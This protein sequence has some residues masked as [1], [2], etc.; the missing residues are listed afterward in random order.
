MKIAKQNPERVAN[1]AIRVPRRVKISSENGT[2]VR[3]I[4]AAGP[5]SQQIGPK[6]AD[7]VIGSGWFRICAGFGDFFAVQIDHET[8]GHADSR[9]CAVI[10]RDARHQR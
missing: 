9:W 6:T 1:A 3:V 8:V 10:Q 2:S 7:E 4:N 5:K